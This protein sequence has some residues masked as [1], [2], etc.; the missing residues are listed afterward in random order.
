MSNLICSRSTTNDKDQL[1]PAIE[2]VWVPTGSG[3]AATSITPPYML[4]SKIE[5][6]PKCAWSNKS[7]GWICNMHIAVRVTRDLGYACGGACRDPDAYP[8]L[9]GYSS[10][11]SEYP[12]SLQDLSKQ[13]WVKQHHALSL[14]MTIFPTLSRRSFQVLACAMTWIGGP[15]STLRRATALGCATPQQMTSD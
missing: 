4:L 3:G 12:R 14:I 6:D 2:S 11:S 7:R 1:Q 15:A 10:C 5:Q 8:E 13:D 9:T